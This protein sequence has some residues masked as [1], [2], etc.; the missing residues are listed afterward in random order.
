[1]FEK[2]CLYGHL[3]AAFVI[4]THDRHNTYFVFNLPNAVYFKGSEAF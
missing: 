2:S 4:L 1:M 3:F